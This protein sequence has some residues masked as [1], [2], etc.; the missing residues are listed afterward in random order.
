[1]QAFIELLAWHF[2]FI[3][4]DRIHLPAGKSGNTF[5]GAIGSQLIKSA[6]YERIFAPVATAGPSGFTDPPRPFVLRT[7]DLDARTLEPSESFRIDMNLFDVS[8]TRQTD[9][10]DAMNAVAHEGIGPGRGRAHLLTSNSE[11]VRLSLSPVAEPVSR[12]RIHFLTPTELKAQARIAQSPEFEVLLARA[13]DRV[14]SLRALYGAG[15]I[16][17]D[18]KGMGHRAAAVRMTRCEIKHVDVERRSSRTGQVHSVGGFTGEAD[19][20]GDLREFMPFLEAAYWT[21][22]GRHT[23]WGNGW[24]KVVRLA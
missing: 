10:L 16:E 14:S 13:R 12:A 3:A 6:A 18:F 21:G 20:E 8:K 15:P 22:V 17:M 19:Y 5:R 1:M 9:L 7:A 23:V 24:I 4:I 2:E 11:V